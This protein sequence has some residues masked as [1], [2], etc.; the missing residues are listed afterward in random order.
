MRRAYFCPPLEPGTLRRATLFATAAQQARLEVVV[1]LSQWVAD[2]LHPAVHAREKWLSSQVLQ[3]MSEIGLVTVNPGWFADNYLAALEAAAQ[4]GILA[5]PL[6]EGR[7][8]PPATEDIA[9]V[10]TGALI[11]PGPHLGKTYRP[12]GPRLLDPGEIADAFGRALERKVEYRDTPL[13]LFLKVAKSL[14]F[15]DFVI[16]Q[17][18]W[19]LQ[20]Y[21]DDAFGIGAPTDAVL[22]VG[23]TPP[24][25]FDDI[26][27][28]YARSSP[29]A[30]RSVPAKFRAVAHRLGALLT[31]APDLNALAYQA[32]NPPL[33]NP[34]RA[35]DSLRWQHAHGDDRGQ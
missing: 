4:F 20:D 31:R 9:A 34:A 1:A 32:V 23:G 29:L 3:S 35:V 30:T 33:T 10:I 14:G 28:R 27:R 8:A 21:R 11:D 25:P 22:E 6:G 17:L 26:V 5:M 13:P 18:Y 19:F 12:T 16:G 7:N 24:E 15:S 2:P